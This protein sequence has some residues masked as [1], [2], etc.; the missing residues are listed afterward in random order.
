MPL[1]QKIIE[2][3]KRREAV[4][5]GGGEKAM[6]KQMAMGKLTARDRITTL[7]DKDSF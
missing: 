6:E 4:L 3:Q 5:Q 7:L 1:K 2:L